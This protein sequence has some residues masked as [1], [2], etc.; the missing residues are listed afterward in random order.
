[1]LWQRTPVG[2]AAAEGQQVW[3]APPVIAD[4][5]VG[6]WLSVSPDRNS[7]SSHMMVTL[8]PVCCPPEISADPRGSSLRTLM[9]QVAKS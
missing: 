7:L 8:I 5:H 6:V 3:V 9:R 1:M 4:V 2:A